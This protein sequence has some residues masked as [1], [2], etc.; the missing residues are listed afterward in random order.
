[1]CREAA[2]ELA[3]REGQPPGSRGNPE[4]QIAQVGFFALRN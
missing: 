4:A 3:V 2:A 1:M